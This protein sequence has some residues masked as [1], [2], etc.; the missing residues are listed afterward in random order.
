[1]EVAM[2]YIVADLVIALVDYPGE[3]KVAQTRGTQGVVIERMA[4]RSLR[5][6]YES[7]VRELCPC[8]L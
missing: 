5:R 4:A 2:I 6:N 1:M 8:P 7:V 3:V